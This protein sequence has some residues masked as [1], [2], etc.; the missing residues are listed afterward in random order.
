MFISYESWYI[1]KYTQKTLEDIEKAYD[2]L[3]RFKELDI[4]HDKEEFI[5]NYM[6][7]LYNFETEGGLS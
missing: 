2:L 3:N 6:I 4:D 1:L 7:E 5:S